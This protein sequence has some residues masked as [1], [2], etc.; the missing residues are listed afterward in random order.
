MSEK[1][2][3]EEKPIGERP[4]FMSDMMRA[5]SELETEIWNPRIPQNR[6][7][8]QNIIITMK[9]DM[10]RINKDMDIINVE[11]YKYRRVFE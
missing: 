6:V 7:K 8:M 2:A 10:I 4:F 9:A 11:G 5:L 3:V 1:V